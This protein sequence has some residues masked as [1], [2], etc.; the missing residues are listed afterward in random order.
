MSKKNV[1]FNPKSNIFCSI[2]R[3]LVID[4]LRDNIVEHE[5]VTLCRYFSAETEVQVPWDKEV[6]RS[7]VHAQLNRSL[8]DDRAR[9]KQH[10]YHIAPQNNGFLP[11]RMMVSVIRAC[12]LP[13]DIALIEKLLSV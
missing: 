7:A 9:I 1:I 13:F 11:Q 3:E 4:L 12:K 5:I 8:W 2:H 6:I 10:I